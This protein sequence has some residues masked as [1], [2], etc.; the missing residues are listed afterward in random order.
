MISFGHVESD[1]GA[2]ASFLFLRAAAEFA[3]VKLPKILTSVAVGVLQR[4]DRYFDTSRVD[5]RLASS[6]FWFLRSCA[7]MTSVVRGQQ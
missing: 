4:F 6:Y 1:L 2:L 7:E 3:A 5:A